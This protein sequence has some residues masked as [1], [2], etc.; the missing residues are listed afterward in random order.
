MEKQKKSRTSHL[1]IRRQYNGKL[2]QRYHSYNFKSDV[3]KTA[4]RLRR[5]GFNVRIHKTSLE[6]FRYTIYKRK[7]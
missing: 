6:K 4:K 2:Y 1:L 5:E 3:D 7:K